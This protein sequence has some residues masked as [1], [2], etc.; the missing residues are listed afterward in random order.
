MKTMRLVFL[1]TIV[2]FATTTFAGE[3][4]TWKPV[5]IKISLEHALNNKA[6]ASEMMM[7]LNAGFLAVEQP[8]LYCA[9]LR[10]GHNNYTIY[11]KYQEWKQFFNMISWKRT[12][13][14][15]GVRPFSGN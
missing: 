1:M 2:A 3:H 7:H 8:G 14:A 4:P 15:V 12:K 11:G 5:D 9:K 6:L 13:P 10:F